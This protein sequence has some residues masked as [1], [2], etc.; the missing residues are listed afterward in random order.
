MKD[1][2]R[3]F[4]SGDTYFQGCWYDDDDE[5]EAAVNAYERA[6]EL[7]ADERRDEMR[8]SEDVRAY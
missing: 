6:Q 8:G 7:K 2:T 1:Y 5:L 4:S 3:D